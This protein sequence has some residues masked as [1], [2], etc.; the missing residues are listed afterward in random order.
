MSVAWLKWSSVYSALYDGTTYFLFFQS[1]F[2]I[3]AMGLSFGKK[4]ESDPTS[5]FSMLT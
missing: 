2:V 4:K 3:T 1:V 5:E